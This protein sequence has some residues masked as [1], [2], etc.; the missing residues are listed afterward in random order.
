MY[1]VWFWFSSEQWHNVYKSLSIYV[2]L[3][4]GHYIH[5]CFLYF[6]TYLWRRRPSTVVRDRILEKKLLFMTA[7]Y[8]LQQYKYLLKAVECM[9]DI[10]N[11]NHPY[12]WNV[13]IH[14]QVVLYSFIHI[15]VCTHTYATPSLF[16]S[17]KM[18][19]CN[20]YCCHWVWIHTLYFYY[21]GCEWSKQLPPS[22]SRTSIYSVLHSHTYIHS[23]H[24]GAVQS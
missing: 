11:A 19:L 8:S 18:Y 9:R 21:L 22:F 16:H 4:E 5:S 7:S 17:S 10:C 13:T 14:L 23:D 24:C 20:S 12:A 1:Y 3:C 6:E 15:R 2:F